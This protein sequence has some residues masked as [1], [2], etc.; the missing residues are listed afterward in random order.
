M[1]YNEEMLARIR[2]ERPNQVIHEVISFKENELGFFDVIV[3]MEVK[4]FGTTIKHS[5]SKLPYPFEVYNKL[6]KKESF[7]W[8][9]SK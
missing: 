3:D 8:R 1:R 2:A 4:F 9:W 7:K 6:G 5:T